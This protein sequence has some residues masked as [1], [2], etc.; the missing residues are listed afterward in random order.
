MFFEPP[1]A[2]EEVAGPT[3]RPWALPPWF[4]PPADEMGVVVPVGTVVARTAHVA[5]T[6]P[7][8]RAYGSGC[9]IEVEILVRQGALSPSEVWELHMSLFPAASV[10]SRGDGG[11]LPDRLLRFGVRYGDGTKATTVEGGWSLRPDAEP[12]AG[13]RLSWQ[14][15][16][17]AIRVGQEMHVSLATLWL[18]P[19]P[20]AQDV[21][22]AVEWPLG[23][24]ELAFAPLDGAAVVAAA[25]RVE[26]YWPE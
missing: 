21:E 1:P 14:P 16:G 9:S 11:G 20:P 26:P 24:V 4:A 18:W 19:L 13:P 23:G 7:Y 25:Q 12:P 5:V 2:G 3:P 22:F 10:R 6:V 15:T 17:G 8:V